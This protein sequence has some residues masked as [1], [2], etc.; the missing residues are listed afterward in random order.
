MTKGQTKQR[1]VLSLVAVFAAGVALGYAATRFQA[2]SGH[3]PPSMTPVEY[4]SH[5]LERLTDD[6]DLGP[7]QQAKVETILL[8]IG[9]RYDSVREA[10][11]PELE[12]IRAERA[13]R[14]MLVL[15]APQRALYEQILEQRR[16][17]REEAHRRF[18]HERN[19]GRR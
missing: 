16:H 19:R 18:L 11:E 12:A 1:A 10:I 8:E 7:Q 14:I 13:E 4:R 2:R 6:L 9:E 5:L 15:Q 17:R 3:R